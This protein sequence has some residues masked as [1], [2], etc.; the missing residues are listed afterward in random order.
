MR[1]IITII[2]SAF[3]SCQVYANN[4]IDLNEGS[5]KL[6]YDG[7]LRMILNQ[8]SYKI[9]IQDQDVYKRQSHTRLTNA[10]SR[11]NLR[12]KHIIDE[13]FYALGRIEFRLDRDSNNSNQFGS[14]YTRRAYFGIGHNNYGEITVGK[15]VTMANELGSA[16]FDLYYGI[17]PDY[18]P[19]SSNSVIRYDYRGKNLRFGIDYK[20]ADNRDL[21]GEVYNNSISNG[22]SINAIY[23]FKLTND[24]SIKVDGAIGRTNYKWDFDNSKHYYNAIKSSVGY[25]SSNLS[26]GLDFGYSKGKSYEGDI[27][28]YY[29]SPGISKS[30]GSIKI[31]GNYLYEKYKVTNV[32]Y[33]ENVN[34]V[35]AGSS[36]EITKDLM[37]YIE[38][39]FVKYSG[40]SQ[41]IKLKVTDKALGLGF[42][43]Y[44]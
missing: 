9:N 35:L 2:T 1:K 10:D 11:L 29:I 6:S 28:K 24:S 36:K 43:L 21:E 12:L 8:E 17:I 31:Y 40:N 33:I 3:L 37:I 25:I 14:V 34:G 5:T 15:Q 32:G 18:L 20:F 27:V 22:Y 30:F 7:S 44:F 41:L 13:K 16:G 39:K 4:F 26:Y 23:T 19:T 38:G 42:R